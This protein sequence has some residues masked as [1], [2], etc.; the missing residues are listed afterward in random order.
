[1]EFVVGEKEVN[2]VVYWF[3]N[4]SVPVLNS[5]PETEAIELLQKYLAGKSTV[6]ALLSTEYMIADGDIDPSLVENVAD[7]IKS[8]LMR[9]KEES[10]I[11]APKCDGIGIELDDFPPRYADLVKW[12]EMSVDEC[13]EDVVSDQVSMLFASDIDR[14]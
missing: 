7:R 3:E 5:K 14:F 10:S 11:A 1:M 8:A 9:S 13:P 12:S 4:E 2:E 6:V